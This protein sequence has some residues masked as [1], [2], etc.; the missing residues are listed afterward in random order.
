MD[1]STFDTKI[2][3]TEN[4]LVSSISYSYYDEQ[5]D[6]HTETLEYSEDPFVLTCSKEIYTGFP[7]LQKVEQLTLS[8]L[9]LPA[10]KKSFER[11]DQITLELMEESLAP[12]TLK[13][14]GYAH[15]K[16]IDFCEHNGFIAL[17]AQPRQLASCV[18]MCATDT[19]SVS[20]ADTL[21]ASVAFEHVRNFLP[22]PTTDPG[23]RQLMRS[24]R[25]KFCKERNPATPLTLAHLQMMMN[26]LLRTKHH[27][28]NGQLASLVTWRTVWRVVM[29]FYTLGRFSDVSALTR[30]SL[31]FKAQPKP[32]L[33]I[34]FLNGKNDVYSEG[35]ERIVSSHPGITDFVKTFLQKWS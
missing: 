31:K 22:S 28:E 2:E 16:W 1:S 17:P 32:H 9:S 33:I 19:C 18:S 7:E 13:Q 34:S 23:F 5:S 6:R 30:R 12:S 35:C 21:A 20:A 27:G 25:R 29:E 11:G 10:D 15:K 8:C 14:Y 24:I 3:V 4:G 26:H